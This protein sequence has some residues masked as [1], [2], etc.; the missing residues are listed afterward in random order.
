MVDKIAVQ[1]GPAD[2][3]TEDIRMFVTVEEMTRKKIEKEYGYVFPE[4]KK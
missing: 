3:P 4:T 1:K 2:R